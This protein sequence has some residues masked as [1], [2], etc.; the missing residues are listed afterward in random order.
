MLH[1]LLW[2]FFLNTTQRTKKMGMLHPGRGHLECYKNASPTHLIL[3]K[4]MRSNSMFL[5]GN[6]RTNIF[7]GNHLKNTRFPY[8]IISP[9]ISFL[10][11]SSFKKHIFNLFHKIIHF[12][13]SKWTKHIHSLIQSLFMEDLLRARHHCV[14]CHSFSP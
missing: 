14:H 5:M 13:H 11:L 7:L 3:G 6:K 2:C 8:S 9:S 1:S 10:I 4:Q 12:I